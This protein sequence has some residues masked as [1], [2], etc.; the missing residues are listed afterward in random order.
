MIKIKKNILFG[1]DVSSSTVG[2]SCLHIC[3]NKVVKIDYSYYKPKDK[4]ETELGRI[5]ELYKFI[6]SYML[7]VK[8][9]FQNENVEFK[10]YVEDFIMFMPGK[11]SARTITL[12]SVYNRTVCL[13]AYHCLG[14]EPQL[15]PV[16][17]IRSILRKMSG[18]TDRID[19]EHVPEVLEIIINKFS[20]LKWKFRF[21]VNSKNNI[22]E[23]CYDMGDGIAVAVAGAFTDEILKSKKD[24]KKRSL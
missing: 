24:E 21:L 3:K 20:S 13:A 14:V 22:I 6:H 9:Q 10:A 19:K 11:S 17:T 2:I 7:G 18:G 16:A 5:F 8:E 23:E 12:L 4:S 1:F 15:L